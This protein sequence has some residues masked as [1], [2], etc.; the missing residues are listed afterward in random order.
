[1]SE[2]C[3]TFDK[4]FALDEYK[5]LSQKMQQKFR[6][7]SSVIY[8]LV[9]ARPKV[10]LLNKIRL[11][12]RNSSRNIWTTS[13]KTQWIRGTPFWT[14]LVIFF[15]FYNLLY[16]PTVL[17]FIFHINIIQFT[18]AFFFFFFNVATAYW[19]LSHPYKF[20]QLTAWNILI[21]ILSLSS[22]SSCT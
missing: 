19:L 8:F 16:H 12:L 13:I 14:Y 4:K 10:Y 22:Q 11:W 6:A 3:P 5:V 1:M 21:R 7:T 20:Q 9:Q 18:G 15:L 17:R 2:F